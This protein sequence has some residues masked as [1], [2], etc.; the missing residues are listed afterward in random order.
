M[1]RYIFIFSLFISSSLFSQALDTLVYKNGEK[2]AVR[3][4]STGDF[5]VRYSIPPGDEQ[6]SVPPSKLSFIIYSDGAKYSVDIPDDNQHIERPSIVRPTQYTRNF[7]KDTLVYKTGA[8]VPVNIISAGPYSVVYTTLTGEKKLA[9]DPSDLSLIIYS[10]GSE[11]SVQIKKTNRDR[12]DRINNPNYNPITINAGVGV[13]TITVAVPGNNLIAGDGLTFLAQSPAYNY[14]MDYRVSKKWSIGIGGAYQ[15]VTDNPG[16]GQS[17]TATWE[18]EKISR[19]NISGLVLY[20]FSRT[21]LNDA[22]IGMRIGESMW[23]DQIISN[24]NNSPG[25][26]LFYTMPTATVQRTSF[27][28]L[29]GDRI[30]LNYNIGFHAEFGIGTP[31]FLE[32]GITFRFKTK[33]KAQ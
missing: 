2:L 16:Y 8:K 12:L 25:Y 5:E 14:T 22:Y 31:Y 17:E 26:P 29:I 32:A 33:S 18:T 9:V 24:I 15:W 1:R 13:S 6:L 7:A 20:H 19:Y 21:I 10:D 3:I 23:T 30:F 11:Y 28:A 27:Q 4:I